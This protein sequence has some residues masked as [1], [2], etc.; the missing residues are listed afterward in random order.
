MSLNILYCEI[1]RVILWNRMKLDQ[2]RNKH[3]FRNDMFSC[4]VASFITGRMQVTRRAVGA[5]NMHDFGID[6]TGNRAIWLVESRNLVNEFVYRIVVN[7]TT[8]HSLVRPHSWVMAWP[9][10]FFPT[11]VNFYDI[12]GITLTADHGWGIFHACRHELEPWVRLIY[13]H[14]S[15]ECQALLFEGTW[16]FPNL[17]WIY[18][19][20]HCD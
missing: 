7:Y 13:F 17:V 8:T 3:L 19:N 10:T 1:I 12:S 14:I 15:C 11:V 20:Q 5:R 6:L 2:Y 4:H 18:K 16:L 9:I